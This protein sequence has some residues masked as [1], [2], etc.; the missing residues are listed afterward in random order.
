MGIPE[1]VV[2]A[3]ML[4]APAMGLV[5]VGSAED[6]TLATDTIV[7]TELALFQKPRATNKGLAI[8]PRPGCNLP[9]TAS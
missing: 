4:T 9:P 7:S 8:Y 3:L 1:N 5:S 6:T 2:V